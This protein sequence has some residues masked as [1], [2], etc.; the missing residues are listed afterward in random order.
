MKTTKNKAQSR[1]ADR[2]ASELSR[3]WRM[4]WCIAITR[5]YFQLV[6]ELCFLV[7]LPSWCWKHKSQVSKRRDD[8]IEPLCLLQWWG[9]KEASNRR[10]SE[11]AWLTRRP[12]RLGYPVINTDEARLVV[13][14]DI[15]PSGVSLSSSAELIENWGMERPCGAAWPGNALRTGNLSSAAIRRYPPLASRTPLPS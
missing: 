1:G 5:S 10:E 8:F 11:E 12:R 3:V 14:P 6:L 9:K 15:T 7:L 4:V 2:T 13:V